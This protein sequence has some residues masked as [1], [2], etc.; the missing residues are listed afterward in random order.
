MLDALAEKPLIEKKR[1]PK[2]TF[3]HTRC[4]QRCRKHIMSF[5]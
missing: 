2:R 3:V 5:G 1:D 4:P